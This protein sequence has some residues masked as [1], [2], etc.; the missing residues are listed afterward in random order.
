MEYAVIPDS[1]TDILGAHF[2]HARSLTIP[3]NLTVTNQSPYLETVI[4]SETY[5]RLNYWQLDPS[6]S[7][8]RNLVILS[9]DFYLEPNALEFVPNVEVYCMVDRKDNSWVETGIG[10]GHEIHYKN[11]W[12]FANFYA[13]GITISSMPLSISDPVQIPSDEAV[14]K[15]NIGLTSFTF[16]GWD[17]NGDGKADEIPALL[18]E[19]LNAVALFEANYC[20]GEHVYDYVCDSMCNVCGYQRD[21]THK[22]QVKKDD[23]GHWTE[24][25]VCHQELETKYPHTFDCACEE[26]CNV[27]GMKTAVESRLLWEND[28]TYHWAEC[29]DCGKT[30]KQKTQ[31]KFDSDCDAECSS[32]GYL[33]VAAEHKPY[34]V[35][36]DADVHWTYCEWCGRWI[37]DQEPHKFDCACDTVCDG[38]GRVRTVTP[39]KVT[40]QDE[41]HHWTECAD[42]GREIVEKKPHSFSSDCDATCNGCTYTRE[43]P[44]H[45]Y[46]CL[47]DTNCNVCNASRETNVET[48]VQYDADGHWENCDI[49]GVMVGKVE[50]H[51][52]T[53]ETVGDMITYSCGC[54]FSETKPVPTATPV[55]TNTPMPT[56]TPVPT[57]TP[58]PTTAPAPTDIPAGADVPADG[59]SGNPVI[60]IV[61]VAAVLLAAGGVGVG[62]VLKKK[63]K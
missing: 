16:V 39:E 23:F 56:A 47:C 15:Q 45:V 35:T 46:D 49:C 20:T 33:R 6:Y 3:N 59:D 26:V 34:T 50:K 58:V 57:N 44:E 5:K 63:Q 52:L 7:T 37:E 4:L 22:E 55:P 11:E 29:P 13:D 48:N 32:C 19:D 51:T 10:E 9:E 41:E 25:S 8:I 21:V 38:C 36:T 53:S 18:T 14:T 12:Y 24:C 54:G 1:V 62:V 28:D 60:L 61:I 42:C 40:K 31:H 43:V 30:V 2:D 17:I 27:C